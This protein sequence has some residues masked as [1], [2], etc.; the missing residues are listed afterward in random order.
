MLVFE[1]Y[2]E[3]SEL[4]KNVSKR[5]KRVLVHDSYVKIMGIFT[6]AIRSRSELVQSHV[7]IL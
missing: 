4:G 1:K 5:T 3:D 2:A 6:L 7:C